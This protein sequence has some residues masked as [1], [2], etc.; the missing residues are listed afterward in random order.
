MCWYLT[1]SGYWWLPSFR[2]RKVKTGD[3]ALNGLLVPHWGNQ[4]RPLPHIPSLRF[5]EVALAPAPPLG[6]QT[7][8]EHSY[9]AKNCSAGLWT[10]QN[11]SLLVIECPSVPALPGLGE[12][13]YLT[14]AGNGKSGRDW[15][16]TFFLNTP[17]VSNFNITKMIIQGGLCCIRKERYMF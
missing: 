6:E 16:V 14:V 10:P 9:R 11:L 12:S 7:T 15:G 8:L 13:V 1:L 5:R 2:W 17:S 4:R 3:T